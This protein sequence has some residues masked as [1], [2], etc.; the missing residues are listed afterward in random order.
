M[1]IHHSKFLI[2]SILDEMKYSLMAKHV[3]REANY[4]V[5][6]TYLRMIIL[7]ATNENRIN[8]LDRL[9]MARLIY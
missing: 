1:S 2:A 8:I 4:K 7:K 5:L 9:Q 3:R 6:D